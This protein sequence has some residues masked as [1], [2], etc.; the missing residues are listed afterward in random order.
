M[1]GHKPVPL[2]R[3]INF[4]LMWTS[5]AASGFGDRM[6]ML[7]ALAL[8]GGLATGQTD[9]T[10]IQAS[11]QFWFFLPYLVFTLA[12]GYLADRLPRKWLM[13]GCDESRAALLLFACWLLVGMAGGAADVPK[14]QH[15]KV[16]AVLTCVGIFAAIFSP[17]RNAI[18]P[19]IIPKPQLQAANAIILVITVVAS[20]IGMLLGGY[21][22]NPDHASSVQTGLLLGAAFYFTSGWF[23]AFLR[24][25]QGP[26]TATVPSAPRFGEVISFT[27]KHRRVA[28]LIGI[29]ILVWASAAAVSSAVLG[30]ARD[31][32]G[33][34]GD[35]LL[36]QYTR[37]SATMGVGMLVGA[38]I[39]TLIN[40]R[41]ES[42]PIIFF[43]VFAAGLCVL[44][45][46]SIKWLPITYLAALGV[47]IFGNIA[48]VGVITLMQCL[49]P[50]YIRGRVMGLNGVANTTFSV[51]TYFAIW[52]LPNAD[53]NIIIVLYVL[54][55]SL[56]LIALFG[57][58]RVMPTGPTD[59]PVFNALWRL[60]RLFTLVWHRLRW[61]GRH[62]VPHDGPV[63]LASNHTT[64]LDP[65][66]IQAAVPRPV[67]WLMMT[68]YRFKILNPFWKVVQP[69]TLD[70]GRSVL[71]QMRALLRA[72]RE[73]HTIGVFPEGGLQ[74]TERELKPF[75]PGV[76][77]L[78]A[79]SGAT[80]VPVWIA[81]TPRRQNMWL[82]FLQPSRSTVTFGEPFTVLRDADPET[83]LA[84][85]RRRMEALKEKESP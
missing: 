30:I 82:H 25:R 53:R 41:R 20:M 64:G 72:L 38:A 47:G 76:V 5:T 15:W 3:N 81:G 37:I 42:T 16:Y 58:I 23:F 17:T 8:L 71:P 34:E 62:H 66:L 28:I 31:H 22:V 13:L 54:G 49:T 68:S 65:L 46:G 43:A 56:C 69:V 61:V 39:I 40:T 84:D 75:E 55:P 36:Q 85:L 63:I 74:R 83:V 51:L 33:F 19:Q 10:G 2:Y 50:N 80:I 52:Q 4:T 59:R 78:A 73:E 26:H 18:I 60:D 6:I 67:R 11:T 1:P 45:L 70:A 48:I 32:Y 14:D 79:H 9:S 12:G 21:I 35:I 77:L 57:L 44:L 27:L 29:N 7:A 24:P